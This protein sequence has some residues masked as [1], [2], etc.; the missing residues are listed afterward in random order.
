MID[1]NYILREGRGYT[2]LT[3]SVIFLPIFVLLFVIMKSDSC[4]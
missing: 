1:C 2:S 4:E 3:A